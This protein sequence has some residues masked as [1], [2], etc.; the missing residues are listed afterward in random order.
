M[1][2]PDFLPDYLQKNSI[3]DARKPGDEDRLP[4]L[5]F[6]DQRLAA[7]TENLY[8]ETIRRAEGL[9]LPR[10]LQHTGG[11]QLQAAKILGITRG[12]LRNKLR[13]LGITIAKTVEGGDEASE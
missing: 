2:I 7:G 10:V 6:V 8:E 1:L 5:K 9:L 12:S 4:L 13:Q 11:N 3:A